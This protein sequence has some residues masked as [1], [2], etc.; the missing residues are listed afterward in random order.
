MTK[1]LEKVK[2]LLIEPSGSFEGSKESMSKL[3][4]KSK[5]SRFS[6]SKKTAMKIEEPVP[7]ESV[8]ML[9]EYV[10]TTMLSQDEAEIYEEYEMMAKI[11]WYLNVA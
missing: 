9:S 8:N 5:T 11:D 3:S 1:S 6:S 10:K 2:P 7:P 4:I